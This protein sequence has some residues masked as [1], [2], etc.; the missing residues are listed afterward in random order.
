MLLGLG[1]EYSQ[2]IREKGYEVYLIKSK[3]VLVSVSDVLFSFCGVCSGV[4]S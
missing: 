4:C 3:N 1:F 2:Q